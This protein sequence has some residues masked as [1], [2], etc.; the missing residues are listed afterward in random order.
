MQRAA[1]GGFFIK[2]PCPEAGVLN[3]AQ[4]RDRT[5][6]LSHVKGALAIRKNVSRRRNALRFAFLGHCQNIA[7][8][9]LFSSQLQVQ[10]LYRDK[11]K[12]FVP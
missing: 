9:G 3:G 4:Y 12:R 2:N 6:D 11:D 1:T 7:K 10:I 8:R 5:Y